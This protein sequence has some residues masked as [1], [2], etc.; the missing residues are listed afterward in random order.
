MTQP[1]LRV[2]IRALVA[3]GTERFEDAVTCGAIHRY[4]NHV[5]GI[6]TSAWGTLPGVSD[7][8]ARDWRTALEYRVDEAI[9]ARNE[10]E[11]LADVLM[12]IAADIEGTDIVN[13]TSFDLENQDLTPYLPTAAGYS[14]Q[15]RSRPGGAGIVATPRDQ[16][17]RDERPPLVIPPEN[18]RLASVGNEVLPSTRVVEE[19]ITLGTGTGED[20][21]ISGGR[22]TYFENGGGDALDR[23]VQEYRGN[24]LLLEAM[25]VE[26]GS[27]LRMPLSDLIMNAWS[28]S[29]ET[30][31]N[32]A[33]LLHSVANSYETVRVNMEEE[34]KNLAFYWDGISS[35][36]FTK[37]GLSRSTWIGQIKAQTSWL[38]EEGKKA[39]TML[40][41]LRNAYASAGYERMDSLLAAMQEY[42]SRVRGLFS[43]CSK[44]EEKLLDVAGAF[45]T[46]LVESERRAID[47]LVQLIKIDEQERKERPDLGTR[48]HDA[49]PPP[50]P[51]VGGSAW[52]DRGGW[53]PNPKRPAL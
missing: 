42:A 13:A 36:A 29:P 38:A 43:P 28:S 33:D 1:T 51:A 11:Q 18:T 15:V 21:T 44:A 30:I 12:Q 23:F 6:P 39:A 34:T 46:F 32:R 17:N 14:T 53:S 25:L 5:G 26:I 8:L 9:D 19:P 40:E 49:L 27:G 31:R 4:L 48:G 35:D 2:E 45:I 16:H 7:K 37:H 3:Y 52:A 41:G 50:A 22:T 24:L 10:M 20:L 47:E